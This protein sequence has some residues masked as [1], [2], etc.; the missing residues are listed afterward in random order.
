MLTKALTGK[1]MFVVSEK[2]RAPQFLYKLGKKYFGKFNMIVQLNCDLDEFDK[3]KQVTF[4]DRLSYGEMNIFAAVDGA[5]QFY[6]F[7]IDEQDPDLVFQW[8]KEILDQP[9]GNDIKQQQ[10]EEE[11]F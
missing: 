1:H 10:D 11:D 8:T 3:Y 4:Q 2:R 6:P 5:L 9:S 7:P